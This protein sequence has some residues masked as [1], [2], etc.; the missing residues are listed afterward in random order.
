MTTEAN[1]IVYGVTSKT[2]ARII[3]AFNPGVGY[4]SKCGKAIY[5][6]CAQNGIVEA[7]IEA[8]IKRQR[9]RTRSLGFCKLCETILDMQNRKENS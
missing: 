9:T 4:R 8:V 3:H 7:S 1:A 2:R 5:E 6:V